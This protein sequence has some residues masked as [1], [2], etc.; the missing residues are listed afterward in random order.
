MIKQLSIIGL[1]LIG[2]SLA[3]ALKRAGYCQKIVAIGRN[4]ARLQQAQ[5]AGIVD[6]YTDD[7]AA[8]VAQADVVFI[9]VPLCA[10]TGVFEQIKN[11]LPAN[12]VITD[13]GSA[14]AC[15][16]EDIEAVF[17]YVPALFVP[18][19]PIAGTEKS[20]HE[21]AFA[22]LYDSRRVILTPLAE[23]DS[24]ALGVVQTMWQ[25]AG[26]IVENT[27][28]EHHDRVL[29][30]T[31]HLPHM[32]AY[33]LVDSLAKQEDVEEI[34]RFAAGG[35]R[36][37]TRIAAADPVMWRDIC[38]RNRTAI[39]AVLDQY[40]T[41]LDDLRA[42]IDQGDGEVLTSIFSRAKSARDKFSY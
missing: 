30:A 42:A 17:G 25:A 14:K 32:L 22:E 20:G 29:A 37:F 18:G 35:F 23:T 16:V 21:A 10:F 28:V 39:L 31:S 38:L 11:H 13:A 5:A 4:P 2:G 27:S 36:D 15:V 12:A 26:A 40:R 34:F 9:A 8:G 19:H 3:L 1:G 7:Y 24:A 33:G 41:E 6:E